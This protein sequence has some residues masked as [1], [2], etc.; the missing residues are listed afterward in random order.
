MIDN[1]HIGPSGKYNMFSRGMVQD[2]SENRQPE[3]TYRYGLNGVKGTLEGDRTS[4]ANEPG[5]K[6]CW[7]M[8]EG[9]F[10]LASVYISSGFTAVLAVNPVTGESL[11]GKGFQDCRFE[12][13]V[14][15]NCLN[16][17]IAHQIQAIGRIRI[18]CEDAIYWTDDLNEVRQFNFDSLGNYYTEEYADHIRDGKTP[19]SFVGEKWDC[20]KFGLFRDF[21]YGCIE[22]AKVIGG[23][24]L[25]SGSMNFALRWLDDDFNPTPW[26]P[27]TNT[28][29]IYRE[30]TNS[31]TEYV[32]VQ[33]SSNVETDVNG[34]T[35]NSNKAVELTISNIDTRFS[36]YQIA[37]IHAYS[38]TGKVTEVLV[39]PPIPI[40]QEKY[41]I[42]GDF[43]SYTPGDVA[44]IRIPPADIDRAKTIAQLENRLILGNVKGKEYDVC[45]FQRHASKICTSYV[46][47]TVDIDDIKSVGD[48]KNPNTL[49]MY[50][51]HQGDEVVANAIVYVFDDGRQT[52]AYHIPGP[53][54]D[55]ITCASEW[56]A[57]P[58]VQNSCLAV[59]VPF[60]PTPNEQP[61]FKEPKVEITYTIN[62]E[63]FLFTGFLQVGKEPIFKVHCQDSFFSFTI[64]S[65][66]V[67]AYNPPVGVPSAGIILTNYEPSSDP[68]KSNCAFVSKNMQFFESNPG[69]VDGWDTEIIETW[70]E[71]LSPLVPEIDEDNIPYAEWEDGRK[72]RRWQIENTAIPF[73]NDRGRP[74]Y[75]ECKNSVYPDIRD[76]DGKS[77][78][79]VDAC[80]NPLVG[81]PIRH[82]RMPD[83]TIEPIIE[84]GINT[85]YENVL[86]LHILVDGFYEIKINYTEGGQN[87]T[88]IATGGASGKDIVVS[89]KEEVVFISLEIIEGQDDPD[90][91]FYKI[92]LESVPQGTQSVR[93]AR[94]LGFEFSNIEYPHPDIVGH[95]FVTAI[96]DDVNKTVV[97]AGIVNPGKEGADNYGFAYFSNNLHIPKSNKE[98]VY[99]LTPEF[100]TLGKETAG[101]QLTYQGRYVLGGKEVRCVDLD[102]AG[103]V[104]SNVDTIIDVRRQTYGA[105]EP[106]TADP[107]AIKEVI[108]LGALGYKENYFPK[109]D[110]VNTS[111]TNR[112][113]FLNLNSPMP[114]R[115]GDDIYYAYSRRYRD[116]YCDL[117]GIVYRPMHNCML[118]LGSSQRVFGGDTFI[119]PFDL[120]NT[121]L[122]E[123]YDSYWDDFAKYLLFV[124]ALGVS[125]LTLGVA[126]PAALAALGSVISAVIAAAIVGITA[127]A[128]QAYKERF[129]K[130]QYYRLVK[131]AE[132][133]KGCSQDFL[134]DSF[135]AYANERVEGLYVESQI[136][137][138][139]RQEYVGECGGIYKGGDILEFFKGRVTQLNP[140]NNKYQPRAII[141]PEIYWINPD[142]SRVD[143]ETLFLPISRTFKCCSKCLEEHRNRIHWSEQSFQEERVDNYRI[144]LPNNYKDIDAQ[145]GEINNII[146]HH[147]RVLILTEDGL[148][149]SVASLQERVTGDVITFIGTGQFLGVPERKGIDDEIGA[150]G[151][152]H[153]WGSIKTRFGVFIADEKENSLYLYGSG[154][155]DLFVGRMKAWA[156]ENFQPFLKNYLEAQG[157]FDFDRYDNPANP[158]GVGIHMVYDP[159]FRRVLITKRDYE[160]HFLTRWNLTRSNPFTL[161]Y[162]QLIATGVKSGELYYYKGTFFVFNGS[163][164]EEVSF[165]DRR[166]FKDKSFT[167]SYYPEGDEFGFFHSYI[168]LIYSRDK[169]TFYAFKDNVAWKHNQDNMLSFFGKKYPFVIEAVDV[170]DSSSDKYTDYLAFYTQAKRKAANGYADA[171]NK[172]FGKVV[173]FNSYQTTGL[174]NIE[175]SDDENVLLESVS[176]DTNTIFVER[177]GKD[178]YINDV[179][180]V[181]RGQEDA[182]FRKDWVSI[183]FEYPIDKVPNF[184]IQNTINEWQELTPL[185]DKYVAY[186]FYFEG[187]EVLVLHYVVPGSY[188]TQL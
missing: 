99:Y 158:N 150:V 142:F 27:A 162:E 188:K 161:T 22:D 13:V 124:G 3:E 157:I 87:K 173:V 159:F 176:E 83:R 57:G 100:L 140:E 175:V 58:R 84:A 122:R 138:A 144:F 114:S 139:L 148:W 109:G 131:D 186:R 151:C 152:Q 91:N 54:P 60:K 128:V 4:R 64:E 90:S 135:I 18:G 92:S 74:G 120:N 16:F 59:Y 180:N 25:K 49:W 168:P 36:Y 77:I 110:L 187:D 48:A 50:G 2:S 117:F 19:A 17:D 82:P 153:Q 63:P 31:Q 108:N 55:S 52:P 35:V 183:Q 51:S 23:G 94:I 164:L 12:E 145:H 104:F 24:N 40:D 106:I 113:Q 167:L 95:Y 132:L 28:I 72:I 172:T 10:Q 115:P 42:D 107:S 78:W 45:G 163:G 121:L 75:Y 76:C 73:I 9:F 56:G 129:F 130:R 126:A 133:R 146:P 11:I 137:F 166:Y 156:Q 123:I 41:I 101:E 32:S 30:F 155:K 62:G 185:L 86:S 102:G 46:V 169:N 178:F 39:S 111:I 47:K 116:V 66:L 103:S 81:T 34:G 119:T 1:K 105:Y 165:L 70:S 26:F 127:I 134:E 65:V 181:T 33:G 171:N 125:I 96:R 177:R 15:S 149:I 136:P 37:V 67:H 160:P 184:D 29:N 170:A 8:P 80:G 44:E 20:S 154:L 61:L 68:V 112:I 79:G 85:Q 174:L 71:K 88:Y 98:L 179:W 143:R 38:F 69:T 5:S 118:T 89:S 7:A 97:D 141:C 6:E 147:E 53:P 182:L 21:K 93:R 14:R 43:S